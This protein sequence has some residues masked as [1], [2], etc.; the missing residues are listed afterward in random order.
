MIHKIKSR[1][2]QKIQ[3]ARSLWEK[4][5]REREGLLL[6]EGIRLLED[7][8]SCGVLIETVFYSPEIMKNPRGARLLESLLEKSPEVYEIPEELILFLSHTKTSQ[9]LSAIVKKPHYDLKS[10]MSGPSSLL[11]VLDEISDPGNLGTII[12]TAAGA[13]A[14]GIFLLP[15][16]VEPWNDKAVRA[17]M[18]AIFRLPVVEIKEPDELFSELALR[19]ILIIAANTQAEKVYFEENLRLPMAF[20]IGN[21]ARGLS[22]EILRRAGA[23]VSIPLSGGVESLNASVA[24][25]L[26]LFEAVRQRRIKG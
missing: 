16:C 1:S 4:D 6:L 8:C 5:T 24:A 12:R 23:S 9:G 3:Y 22:P 21:E 14:D 2:N 18:G 17:S 7:A 10:S 20:L 19:K 25:S 11:L 13:G 26:L 15:G